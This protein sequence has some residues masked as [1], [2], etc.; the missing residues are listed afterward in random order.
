MKRDLYDLPVNRII[1]E[2]QFNFKLAVDKD[3][4]IAIG[5]CTQPII[6]L[7][8]SSGKVADSLKLPFTSCIRDMEF[9]EYDNLLIMDN[10]EEH[11]YKYDRKKRKLETLPYTKPED[12]YTL[13]NH[14]YKY[15]EISSI[16]TF[17]INK[18][19]LQD[20]YYTRFN[21]SYNLWLNYSNGF[22]YQSAY[23]FIRKV[24]NHKTYIALKKSDL[25]FSERLS[26]KSKLLIIDLDNE[27]AVYYNRALILIYE[28]FKNNNIKE[29]N[30][31]TYNSEAVQ[32]DFAT[33]IQQH[34]IWGVSYYGKEK[35]T[36]SVWE[37]VK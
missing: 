29:Y 31:P 26:N 24:G 37:L 10:E 25:W 32:Y 18:D 21:Y 12:W 7:I 27:V 35:F 15:F 3:E 20:S 28:D 22:I 6:F 33:N 2:G 9:D 36:V 5:S 13:I 14:Y 4:T 17:Y 34:K 23:N 19:Y 16:P 1:G 11:I 8:N 30:C